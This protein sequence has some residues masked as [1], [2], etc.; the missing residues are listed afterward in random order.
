MLDE[1]TDLA[2]SAYGLDDSLL[3][4]CFVGGLIPQPKKEVISKAAQTLLQAILLAKL[5]EEKFLLSFHTSRNKTHYLLAKPIQQIPPKPIT[6]NLNTN[7]S[8][9]LLLPTL[10]KHNH[11]KKLTLVDKQFRKEKGLCF[12]CDER[13]APNHKCTIKYYYLLQSEEETEFNEE[14]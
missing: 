9:S 7:T 1:F 14:E 8:L 4:D 11:L 10:P 3:L 13:Y 5:F 6:T 12:T 2:N